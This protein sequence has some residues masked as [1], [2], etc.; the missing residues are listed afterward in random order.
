MV[1]HR[2]LFLVCLIACFTWSAA[3]EQEVTK[4]WTAL[5]IVLWHG[6]GD[7]CCGRGSVGFI[8]RHLEEH[9]GLDVHSLKGTITSF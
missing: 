3:E 7:T 1:E 5:P 8:K 2:V 9:Y 4:E 6:M